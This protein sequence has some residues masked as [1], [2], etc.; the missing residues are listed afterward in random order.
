MTT[1][2][3]EEADALCDRISIIDHGV[4]KV[5]G[6]PSQLKERLGGDI[7]TIELSGGPDITEVLKGL[8]EGFD[9]TR[10]DQVYPGKLPKTEKALPAI[11]G[12]INKRLQNKEISLTK[13]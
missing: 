10:K 2:Y 1:H 13:P 6:S 12:G 8:P 9:L 11:V 4:I 5:S 7:L 3:L